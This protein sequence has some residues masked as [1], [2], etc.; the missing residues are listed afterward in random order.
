VN[1]VFFFN[2]SPHRS[3]QAHVYPQICPWKLESK[4]NEKVRGVLEIK[5]PKKATSITANPK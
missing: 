2:F 4:A 3:D 5:L 1:W